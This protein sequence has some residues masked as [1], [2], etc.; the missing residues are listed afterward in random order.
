[1][2]DKAKKNYAV[3]T[4]ASSGIGR[5]FAKKLA[6]EGYKLVLMARRQKRLEEL[7]KELNTECVIVSGDLSHLED[8]QRLC[9]R[10][11]TLPVG[12]FINNAGFGDCNTFLEGDETKELEMINVNIKAVHFLT[13]R[14][15]KKMINQGGGYILNVAS[16]AGLMPAGPY[17]ATYYA[18]KSYVASLTRAIAQELKERKCPVYIG[19]LCPGPVDTE[20]NQVA[21]AS[22][23]LPG[24][25]PEKCVEYALKKMKKKKVIIVPSFSIKCAAAG[26]KIMPANL[27]VKVASHQQKKKR[28]DL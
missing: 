19:A 21:N 24:I 16:S 4:G 1:M 22:F 6:E 13:K 8:C 10:L 27:V 5:E 3:I 7:A 9:D 11:E 2:N 28:N 25:S 12:I 17:M 20:F 15:L 18:T 26:A 14:M 23:S